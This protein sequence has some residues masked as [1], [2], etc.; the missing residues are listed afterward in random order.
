VDSHNWCNCA[1]ATNHKRCAKSLQFFK[2][3]T[4]QITAFSSFNYRPTESLF[5]YITTVKTLNISSASKWNA[6]SFY[7]TA[8]SELKGRRVKELVL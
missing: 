3:K 8:K 1:T 4:G 6:K 5:C 7:Q 2:T